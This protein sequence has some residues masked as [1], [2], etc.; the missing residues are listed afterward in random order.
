MYARAA[1]IIDFTGGPASMKNTLYLI[2]IIISAMFIFTA[3]SGGGKAGTYTQITQDEAAEMMLRDDGHIIVDVRREDEY[4]QGHIPDAVCIPN[5]S[6][7]SEMPPQLPDLDQIIL[8]Y[9]RS[10]NRS[11][12]AAQK[13][14]DIGYTNVYEFGGIITWTGET[15]TG[16]SGQ[17]KD[18]SRTA[19]LSFSSFDGGGPE[20]SVTVEDPSIVSWTS[21]RDYADE[22]HE[23]LDG[24]SYTVRFE[25][26]GLKEGDT[27]IIVSARSPI[28]DEYDSRYAV[29]VD[30]SLKVTVTLLST[31]Y[32]QSSTYMIPTLVMEVNGRTIYP[33]VKDNETAD[34]FIEKLK[35]EGGI[36]VLP[37]HDYGGFE[38]TGFL[39]WELPKNDEPISAVTGDL[40]LYNGNEFSFIYGENAWE[41]TRIG[42][43]DNLSENELRDI[44]GE[45]DVD[46]T[47][48]LEWPE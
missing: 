46:I 2:L 23:E 19:I 4:V 33:T 39:P 14:A 31:E 16:T 21:R 15:V 8:V 12:Q 42:H 43:V 27:Y 11:K 35:D 26:T 18:M 24:A 22:N 29:S 48:W 44:L 9:C 17:E 30:S 37:L 28:T 5:E 7:G 38:K 41:Y 47:F 1:D 36:I 20:Y 13:L 3:C 6:I 45:G 10:G 34:A 25:F 40:L 32:L